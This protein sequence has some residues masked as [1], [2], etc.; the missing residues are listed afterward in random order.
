VIWSC[1]SPGDTI[2]LGGLLQYGFNRTC[3]P[4]KTICSGHCVDPRLRLP[5]KGC[6][7][8][9][10]VSEN[11]SYDL[12]DV[13]GNFIGGQYFGFY[14]GS[15]SCETD[16]ECD[17]VSELCYNN[18]CFCKSAHLPSAVRRCSP[19]ALKTYTNSNPAT[20][21]SLMDTKLSWAVFDSK[22]QLSY[23]KRVIGWS[24]ANRPTTASRPLVQC[25]RSFC[26]DH[27]TCWDMGPPL[28]KECHCDLYF[29]GPN[30]TLS[31]VGCGKIYCTG[32]GYCQTFDTLKGTATCVC[33]PTSYGPNCSLSAAECARSRC[34][35]KGQCITALQGCLCDDGT[36]AASCEPMHS[37]IL[38]PTRTI[39]KNHDMDDNNNSN[40]ND[41]YD[42]Y[43]GLRATAYI[44][45]FVFLLCFF[46]YVCATVYFLFE[47]RR[48]IIIPLELLQIRA[49]ERRRYNEDNYDDTV[50]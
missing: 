50:D 41:L 12:F 17:P 38:A 31:N 10:P 42:P 49:N 44:A 29:S 5:A 22:T 23:D 43:M 36:I 18:R 37:M 48:A 46:V 4:C 27:G 6:V 33:E 1:T 8:I 40:N 7:P 39:Q 2:D 19:A 21:V 30:C 32:R 28:G 9:P 3:V 34:D 25:P 16:S 26:G 14:Q 35:G 47:R 13:Y 20:Y 11:R 15:R 24:Q 45:L